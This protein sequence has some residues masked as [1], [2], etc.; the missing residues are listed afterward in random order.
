MH[1]Y[2][3]T[4]IHTY[5]RGTPRSQLCI[6]QKVTMPVVSQTGVFPTAPLPALIWS[7]WEYALLSDNKTGVLTEERLTG[8]RPPKPPAAIHSR[9]EHP[10]WDSNS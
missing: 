2:I 6:R 7:S 1:T 9:H 8:C 5:R 3:H 10:P 4:Y